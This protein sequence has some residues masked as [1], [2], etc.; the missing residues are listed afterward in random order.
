MERGNRFGKEAKRF[1]AFLLCMVLIF[2]TD[3]ATAAGVMESIGIEVVHPNGDCGVS[4]DSVK[5]ED[6]GYREISELSNTMNYAVG[7][8]K[9]TEDLQKEI[10]AN[11][12]HDLRSPLTSIKGYLE[13]M[14]DG[15]I[16]PEMHEKYLNIVLNETDRLHKLTNSLLTLNSLNTKG[17]RL[18]KSEFDIN[19]VIRNTAASFEGTCKKKT[20]AIELILTGETM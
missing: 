9:K 16:P 15:T 3:M 7:E 5:Y 12:S 20:I 10:I 11:V 19:Q 17:M 4:G 1:L 13:A 2:P 6:G 8:L 14:I 18:D